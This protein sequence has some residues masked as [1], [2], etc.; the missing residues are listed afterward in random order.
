VVVDDDPELLDP[1]LAL[2]E[3]LLEVLDPL[4]P[5][6]VPEEAVEL[7]LLPP[8]DVLDEL[9]LAPDFELPLLDLPLA[10]LFDVP[11][12][13]WV[14]VVDPDE[15][16]AP[17]WPPAVV[18]PV[19]PWLVPEVPVRAVP[20]APPAPAV[21]PTVPMSAS[22]SQRTTVLDALSNDPFSTTNSVSS[23]SSTLT[24]SSSS[25]FRSWRNAGRYPD[26]QAQTPP[27][28]DASAATTI[29]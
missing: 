23:P 13:S 7:E 19:P 6:D 11:P 24:N 25:E 1:P 17:P 12:E 3:E 18:D 2:L 14:P 28:I 16:A 8:D 26:S 4:D 20:A 5:P 29:A 10:L 9:L 27:Q 22:T 21:P 15:P